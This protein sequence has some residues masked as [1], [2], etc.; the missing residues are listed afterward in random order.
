MLGL[1]SLSALLGLL[2]VITGVVLLMARKHRTLAV[3]CLITGL[4][5]IF[6]PGTLIFLLL[7]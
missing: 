4:L 6:V 5:L 3:V 2:V 1:S 7:D